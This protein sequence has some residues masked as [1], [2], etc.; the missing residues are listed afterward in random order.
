[1]GRKRTFIFLCPLDGIS[2]V[3]FSQLI[4]YVTA[5]AAPTRRATIVLSSKK[6]SISPL[7]RHLGYPRRRSQTATKPC[8]HLRW[9]EFGI[10]CASRDFATSRLP[11]RPTQTPCSS[12][13]PVHHTSPP[14]APGC[15]YAPQQDTRVFAMRYSY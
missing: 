11:S 10:G 15:T 13:L 14:T 7:T 6:M 1:M 3:S 5:I 9:S 8:Q 12:P 2:K 4:F